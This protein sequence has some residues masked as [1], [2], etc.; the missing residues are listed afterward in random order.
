MA[1]GN[2]E[3]LMGRVGEADAH[4]ISPHGIGRGGL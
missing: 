4:Q 3:G 2:V 1:D